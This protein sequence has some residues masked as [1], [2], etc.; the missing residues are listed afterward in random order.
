[1][2]DHVDVN[3]ALLQGVAFLCATCVHWHNG[4]ANGTCDSDGDQV[5]AQYRR[6]KGPL[7]GGGFEQYDGVLAGNVEKFC[8]VCGTKSTH[9][10]SPKGLNRHVGVCITCLERL[11][12]LVPSPSG[13]RVIFTTEQRVGPIL[14]EE[15]GG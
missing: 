15:I 6:C 5:C 8:H 11:R 13:R 7:S 4:V 2:I 3:K 14:Y 12:S 1:M 9:A 10:L